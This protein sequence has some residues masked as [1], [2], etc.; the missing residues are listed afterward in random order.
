MSRPVFMVKIC[1]ISV[2]H[3]ADFVFSPRSAREQAK[4]KEVSDER[5]AKKALL[6]E[7]LAAKRAERLRKEQDVRGEK[8]ADG[9]NTEKDDDDDDDDE[10]EDDDDEEEDKKEEADQY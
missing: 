2:K 10:D 1:V 3:F 5:K 9:V 7:K 6:E 4:K 8:E